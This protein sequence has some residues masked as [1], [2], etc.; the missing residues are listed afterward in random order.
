[1]TRDPRE[2][3]AQDGAFHR[4]VELFKKCKRD[5][6]A[7][8][9]FMGVFADAYGVLGLTVCCLSVASNIMN[10]IILSKRWLR[11][12]TTSILIGIAAMDL[13]VSLSQMPIL[14]RYY[15]VPKFSPSHVTQFNTET[16]R[17]L[18]NCSATLYNTRFDSDLRCLEKAQIV[19]R[20]DYRWI[21]DR[22]DAFLS[23][24]GVAFL[25]ILAQCTALTSH[26]TSV[27]FGVVLAVFRWWLISELSRKIAKMRRTITLTQHTGQLSSSV[28]A[29]SDICVSRVCV[30]CGRAVFL[31]NGVQCGS[32][33]KKGTTQFNRCDQCASM[34]S[35]NDK[36]TDNGQ[37]CGSITG[38]WFRRSQLI[39]EPRPDYISRESFT[40][41]RLMVIRSVETRS[42]TTKHSDRL[43][44]VG[45]T[46][47]CRGADRVEL[48]RAN[49]QKALCLVFFTV[50][51]FL[52]PYY[53][54][55]HIRAAY[56]ILMPCD[57]LNKMKQSVSQNETVNE[58][59]VDNKTHVAA[60]RAGYMPARREEFILDSYNF[61]IVAG[62]GKLAPCC[63][64]VAFVFRLITHL[65][66]NLS[67]HLTF[68]SHVQ[69]SVMIEHNHQSEKKTQAVKK[70]LKNHRRTSRL[71]IL[72]V[73]L[74]LPVELPTAIIL[75][76]KRYTHQGECLYL[77]LGDLLDWLS[78]VK[79]AL[80]FVIYCC[81]SSEF[82]T[83]FSESIKTLCQRT[84]IS[85]YL[86]GIKKTES[87]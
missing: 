4:N 27:W 76:G 13:C 58:F 10:L 43:S 64:I 66:Q 26:T 17:R 60:V 32:T 15:L 56:Y 47:C 14:L 30:Q 21:C 80:T 84:Q 81:M 11:R 50:T 40:E 24:W 1:M 85:N 63:L 34:K 74:I 69:R 61:W 37:S 45:Q 29:R 46:C 6:P 49:T 25:F 31:V 7:L 72:V 79:N 86:C 57:P 5:Y 2:I 33:V 23:Q 53:M 59:C 41:Q 51:L 28:V 78:L 22:S 19:N 55:T 3:C 48:S 82:R 83:A 20:T 73:L 68:S 87:S 67:H 52:S 18:R 38:R 8:I 65:R 70:R 44:P 16:E 77:S 71:L 39:T 42:C 9:T 62:L 75:I 36:Q 54:S 35:N 12:P